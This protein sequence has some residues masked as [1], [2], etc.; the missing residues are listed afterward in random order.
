M[1][2][3]KEDVWSLVDGTEPLPDPTDTNKYSKYVL[4][5]NKALAIVV[6]SVDPKLLY[7][8]GEPE[9]PKEVW[10]KLADQFQKKTWSNKLQLRRRLYALR[11]KEG[12]SVQEH[13]K[14]MTEIFNEL[15]VIGD[16]R[17]EEDRVVHLLASLPE[18]YDMLVTALEANFEI[19]KMEFVTEKIL[20][21][22]RKSL[23]KDN[24]S[25]SVKQEKAFYAKESRK[26]IKCHHC[27][28]EG[29]IKRNCWALKNQHTK[30]GAGSSGEKSNSAE[31]KQEGDDGNESVG[32]LA[33]HAMSACDKNVLD[34]TWIVD[35]GATC[36]MCNNKELF[37]QYNDKDSVSV[38]LG[39]GHSLEAL[40]SGKIIL[41]MLLPDDKIQKCTLS[42]VL[43]IPKLSFNLLSV[44]KSAKLGKV[45]KFSGNECKIFCEKDNLIAF[46][47]KKGNLYHLKCTMYVHKAN[48]ACKLDENIWHRRYG[49]LGIDNLKILVRDD[50]V[51]GLNCDVN[52]ELEFC[53]ACVKGKSKKSPF[54]CNKVK[55]D[56][57]PLE[58]IHSDVCGKIN[59]KS[60][61][62][63]EYFVTFIDDATR[64]VWVYILKG[65]HEVFAK[66]KEWKKC[67]ENQMGRK[68]KILRTDNGGEYKSNDFD[69]YLIDEGIRHEYTIPKT[70]EQ[71]GVSERM[72]RTLV[73][74]IRAM[75]IDS[76]LPHRFWAEALSTACYLKNRSPA[77]ALKGKTPCQALMGKKPTVHHLRVFGCVCYA[78]V[79]KDER[80]QLDPKSV[81]CIFLGYGSEVKGYR[82]FDL[83][84]KRILNSRDAIFDESHYEFKKEKDVVQ[85]ETPTIEIMH[86]EEWVSDDDDDEQPDLPVRLSERVKRPPDMYGEW[87]SV[88]HKTSDPTS[89]SEALLSDDKEHWMDAMKQE[90]SSIQESDVYEL[91]EL[92]KGSKAL[93]CRWVFKKKILSNG[94]VE[95]YKARLVAQGCSQKFGIDYDETFC[96]VARFESV[97]TVLALA[98]Q[99]GMKLH[100][101]DVTTAFLNGTLM[102]EV[103]MKQPDGFVEQGK[104]TMVCKLKKSIY[105]LK[106]SPRCWNYALDSSLRELGFVQTSGDPCIYV[107]LEEFF[108]VAVYVDDI[109]LACNCDDKVRKVKDS[110]ASQFKLKDLGELQYFLGVK[111]VQNTVKGQIWIGQPL[112]IENI[113][114]KFGMEDSKPVETPVD[115]N[116]KVCKVTDECTIFDKE[117]Y[118]SAVGSLLYLSVKTRPDIAYAVNSVTRYSTKP[119][120]QHW[121]AVKRIMRYLKGTRDLGILY[122]YN[123]STDFVGYS[124]ADW[125]GDIKD[126]KSTSGY[127]F[128]LG[129]GPVSWS[130]KKQRCVALSTAEAEYMALA[131]A[132]QEAVWLRKLAVDIQIDCKSPLLLY[133]DNQSTIAMS[134]NPQFHGKTKHIDIKFHYVRE[135]CNENVIQLVYCPIND[136]IADIFTKGLNKD[137]FN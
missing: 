34:N 38:S 122:N 51:D 46:A 6:L 25:I 131:S 30:Q 40:G 68:M 100:H 50:L 32:L 65:K 22:E 58:L 116:Q 19:P 70:P 36:Y 99:R 134:K 127:C 78:H 132:I 53:E 120:S 103:Y 81:K 94:S 72:N 47:E 13:I 88:G 115:P 77:R 84:K 133:E 62:N 95:R 117:Q 39:D 61:S 109:I 29:H 105:G 2:L 57:E 26:T 83:D 16:Q 24:D 27:G 18:S 31:S 4:K 42:D 87:V 71:N 69:Q 128:H 15:S 130:S 104:E 67:V 73:E 52:K 76:G 102:E 82:L 124:D 60:L 5:K 17:N 74:Q 121:K 91:V 75:L 79:P 119:T 37:V 28:K 136:M 7:L 55:P 118:Q 45:T 106:Q 33:A 66:F 126:R 112:Y 56:R 85:T 44:S 3:I 135:K 35:S 98:S 86:S 54:P 9:D 110:L 111:V 21:E 93:K 96:P 123:G 92:P 101:M 11:L 59:K 12:G 49:H 10:N 113:L 43:Y 23:V 1:A 20:H 48:A 8:L 107:N 64:Y 90:M 129:G 137:K 125:A 108:I 80:R 41:K 63:G 97:R 89:V 14:T 114:K